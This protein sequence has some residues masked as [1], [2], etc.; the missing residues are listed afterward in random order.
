MELTKEQEESLLGKWGYLLKG[1]RDR[2]IRIDTA[3]LLED[4]AA[5]MVGLNEFLKLRGKA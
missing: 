2:R 3:A 4:T 5:H 1:I